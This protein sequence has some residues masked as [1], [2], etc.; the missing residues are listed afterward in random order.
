MS[1]LSILQN[2]S[3]NVLFFDQSEVWNVRRNIA[4]VVTGVVR[5]G[6]FLRDGGKQKDTSL[7]L[8][9]SFSIP[10]RNIGMVLGPV[11]GSR[12]R[13]FVTELKRLD[14]SN[15]LVGISANTGRVVEGEHKLV[16]RFQR[17]TSGELF[18]PTVR[19]LP[20]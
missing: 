10:N 3:L 2:A 6:I 12:N 7:V 13:L 11:G 18:V 19:K 20:I 4:G 17:A 16:F 5:V 14:A 1:I 8:R 15:N 9:G